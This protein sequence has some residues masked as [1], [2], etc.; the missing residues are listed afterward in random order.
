MT[1]VGVLVLMIAFPRALLHDYTPGARCKACRDVHRKSMMEARKK[2]LILYSNNIINT[3]ELFVRKYAINFNLCT[4]NELR[5]ISP[6]LYPFPSP[7]FSS[8]LEA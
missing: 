6:S 7:A 2:N 1:L 4:N 3:S 8:Y 5:Y